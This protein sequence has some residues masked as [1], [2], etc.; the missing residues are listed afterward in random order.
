MCV[1]SELV[2]KGSAQSV[3]K[4]WLCV[5]SAIVDV[6]AVGRCGNGCCGRGF[7]R[8]CDHGFCRLA[9]I[10]VG[11]MDSVEDKVRGSCGDRICRRWRWFCRR[12]QSCVVPLA[13]QLSTLQL[14]ALQLSVL[15]LLRL[16]T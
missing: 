8:R 7:R 15:K 3:L 14:L 1:P 6:G 4:Q 5:P 16:K 10:S 13:S 12:L 2:S 9:A 11:A